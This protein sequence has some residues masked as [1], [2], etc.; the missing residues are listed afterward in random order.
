[1]KT[2]NTRKSRDIVPLSMLFAD[3]DQIYSCDITQT[4]KTLTDNNIIFLIGTT[5]R[6]IPKKTEQKCRLKVYFSVT[7][8]LSCHGL[9]GQKNE[10]FRT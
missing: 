10:N 1:M 3:P 5:S 7:F 8:F 6:K 9:V 2:T 4:L